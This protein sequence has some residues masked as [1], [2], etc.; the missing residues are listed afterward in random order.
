M[1][2]SRVVS[3]TVRAGE[4]DA[5]P[6]LD[7]QT[8]IIEQGGVTGVAMDRFSV[9]RIAR[10]LVFGCGKVQFQ[11]PGRLGFFDNQLRFE[12]TFQFLFTRQ[13]LTATFLAIRRT[14]GLPRGCGL[15]D[16]QGLLFCA[17]DILP[18]AVISATWSR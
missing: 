10:P 11:L 18:D 5:L 6:G 4:S 14:C 1:V 16:L 15:F 9:T 17:G 3:R 8:D 7:M 13:G 2:R 12:K